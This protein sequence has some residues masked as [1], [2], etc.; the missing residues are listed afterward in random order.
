MEAE[1]RLTDAEFTAI[2]RAVDKYSATTDEW[3]ALHNGLQ[4]KM[5]EQGKTFITWGALWAV[6]VG[7]A[8]FILGLAM[9]LKK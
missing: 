5:E 2:R 3:K 1:R 7:I 8:S 6:V 4:R 9:Y